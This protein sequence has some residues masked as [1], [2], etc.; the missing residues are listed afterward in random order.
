V[1]QR[2]GEWLTPAA[3]WERMQ[4]LEDRIVQ[5]ESRAMELTAEAR[6]R[7]QSHD[8]LRAVIEGLYPPSE[9][10]VTALR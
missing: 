3:V 7:H 2:A 5:L 10:Y 8:Q 4:S 9:F 6:A 1:R